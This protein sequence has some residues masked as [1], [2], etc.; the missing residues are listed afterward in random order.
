MNFVTVNK[1][2]LH[3]KFEGAA[4][5][6]PLVFINSLGSDL[7]IWDD[8]LPLLP[9]PCRKIRYDKRGH[10]LSDSPAGP[11][12]IR[13]HANDLAGLLDHLQLAQAILIGVSVGGMIALDFAAVF[14]QRVQAL[15]LCDTAAKLATAEYWNERIKAI[16]EQGMQSLVE[17]ILSRW[18]APN[19]PQK[20]PAA[21]QGF[22]NLLSRT[23][24]NGYLATCA[25]LGAADL[26]DELAAIRQPALVL[27]G[28][29]DSATPPELVEGLA[30]GLGN[31][32]F[33]LMPQA[34]HT[35]SVEQPEAVAQAITQF[36][37]ENCYV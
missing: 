25:A 11:Y 35:P 18:F 27:C 32:R 14:P 13:D 17:P 16:Q 10:G 1:V 30:D 31:G 20:Q 36:L 12:T 15:I 6:L 26:R 4:A 2:T 3:C 33:Q 5:G 22:S 19:F 21:Y 23:D 34:G 9:E 7:R 29:E 24:V 28:A 8:V 37:Q